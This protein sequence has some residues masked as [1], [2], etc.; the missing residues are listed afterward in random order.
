MSTAPPAMRR[1][2]SDRAAGAVAVASTGAGAA[3]APSADASW[4]ADCIPSLDARDGA[5][6]A[7]KAPA[8][9]SCVGGAAAGAG[10]SAGAVGFRA[11]S[12]RSNEAACVGSAGAAAAGAAAGAAC[13]GLASFMATRLATKGF[14]LWWW[15]GCAAT[16]VAF[17]ANGFHGSSHGGSFVSSTPAAIAADRCPACRFEAAPNICDRIFK[18]P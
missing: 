16:G 8:S 18:N 17:L 6:G 11:A 7:S 2:R 4:R 15:S 12:T 3:N 1:S 13:L 5:A 14:H 10:A 9:A